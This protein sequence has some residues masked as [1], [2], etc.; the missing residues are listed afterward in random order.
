MIKKSYDGNEVGVV[1][2]VSPVAGFVKGTSLIIEKPDSYQYCRSQHGKFIRRRIRDN[3]AKIILRLTKSSSAN[4]LLNK[5]MELDNQSDSGIFSIYIQDLHGN[6]PFISQSASIMSNNEHW[7]N[8]YK[9]WVI[10]AT[11]NIF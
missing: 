4:A 8:E 5:Y 9:E 2:G 6:N 10:I 1:F 7:Q 3:S 11:D